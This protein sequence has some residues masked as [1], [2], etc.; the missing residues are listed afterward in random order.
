MCFICI[1][2]EKAKFQYAFDW[3]P[4]KKDDGLEYMKVLNTNLKMQVSKATFQ[5]ENIVNADLSMFS[6]DFRSR[7]DTKSFFLV[8][9]QINQ[10]LN[11]SW[12]DVMAEIGIGIEKALQ[13]ILDVI[14]DGYISNVP[15]NEILLP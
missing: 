3:Q 1:F 6:I 12:E 8:G 10:A 11:D 2:L 14:V 13:S 15:Y 5:F 9:K 4:H 7:F